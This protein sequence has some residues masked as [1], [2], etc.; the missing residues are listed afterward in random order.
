MITFSKDIGDSKMKKRVCLF[1]I[2]MGILCSL[3][4]GCSNSKNDHNEQSN[5]T[6]SMIYPST[7]SMISSS[8][9]STSSSSPE[10]SISSLPE[11]TVSSS[12][13]NSIIGADEYYSEHAEVISVTKAKESEKIQS[14]QDVTELLSDRGFETE[15]IVTDFTMDG[16]YLDE[17]EI[18]GSSTKKHPLYKMLYASES[19]ILWNIYIINGVVAAYPVSYN[20]VSERDAIL[21]IT[22]SDT[23]MSYDNSSN[24]FFETVPKESEMIVRKVEKINK[25]TLDKLTIGG[26]S[27]L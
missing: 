9:A 1:G 20:L 23:V 27:E 4:F 11:N 22:E 24:Q 8:P 18:E 25:E 15:N 5:I 6:A 16:V 14:E 2:V 19:D 26:L 3:L 10:S 12:A 13:E 7:A 17:S 21:L